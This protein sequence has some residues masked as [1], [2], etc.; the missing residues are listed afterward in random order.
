MD[1]VWYYVEGTLSRVTLPKQM[2]IKNRRLGLLNRFMQCSC[3]GLLLLYAFS[4]RA[5]LGD[6]DPVDRGLSMWTTTGADRP[7][8]EHCTNI[9]DY[10]YTYSTAFRYNPERCVDLSLGEAALRHGDEFFFLTYVSDQYHWKARPGAECTALQASCAARGGAFDANTCECEKNIDMLVKQPE[11]N[12]LHFI[13]GY[14]VRLPDRIIQGRVTTQAVQ[15]P[16]DLLHGTQKPWEEIPGNQGRILTIIQASDGSPCKVGK[17][18]PGG[19]KDIWIAEDVTENGVQGTIEEWIACGDVDLDEHR[20]ELSSGALGETGKARPRIAGMNVQLHLTYYNNYHMLFGSPLECPDCGVVCYVRVVTLPQWNSRRMMAYTEVPDYQDGAGSYR[21]RYSYGISLE[22]KAR[23][24]FAYFDPAG[25][26]TS[27]VNMIV[28]LQFPQQFIM[29]IAL[30]CIGITSSVY[31]RAA[32][33]EIDIQTASAG[34][35]SRAMVGAGFFNDSSNGK[36]SGEHACVPMSKLDEDLRD[37]LKEYMVLGG[38]IDEDEFTA[39]REEIATGLKK[40]LDGYGIPRKSLV[41]GEDLALG[42]WLELFTRNE[43]IKVEELVQ[44]YDVDR[45][46]T[47]LE[48][49]FTDGGMGKFINKIRKRRKQVLPLP[50]PFPTSKHVEVKEAAS[51]LDNVAVKKEVAMVEPPKILWS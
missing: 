26:I 34:L 15:R 9:A 29:F 50:M 35:V 41:D 7:P 2:A 24:S 47:I 46:R 22:I 3:I 30:F 38:A 16:F 36:K 33:E 5:W 43:Y 10:Q 49:C 48:R 39:L 40:P 37:M 1:A 21:F 28:L 19:A 6:F 4:T 18:Q 14:E 20:S 42:D 11:D 8:R 27:I 23:G 44:F 13:H 32:I 51:T 45:P 12:V 31:Y 17:H 25:L